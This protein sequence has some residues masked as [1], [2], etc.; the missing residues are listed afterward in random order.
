MFALLDKGSAAMSPFVALHSPQLEPL[1][2][3][4]SARVPI[5]HDRVCTELS[6]RHSHKTVGSEQLSGRTTAHRPRSRSSSSSETPLRGQA[7][8]PCGV[9]ESCAAVLRVVRTDV[10]SSSAVS[11]KK[12]NNPLGQCSFISP[13]PMEMFYS[14]PQNLFIRFHFHQTS[15]DVTDV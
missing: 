12:F 8:P 4:S 2:P 11:E 7:Q 14:R 9:L 10:S 6:A 15:S 3:P 5:H 1:P 13:P